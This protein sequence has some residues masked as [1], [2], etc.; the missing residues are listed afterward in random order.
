MERPD[1][2][3][4]KDSDEKPK[5]VPQA[6]AAENKDAGSS[7]PE[8][9]ETAGDGKGRKGKDRDG[10]ARRVGERL[11]N[12]A[13]QEVEAAKNEIRTDIE[14]AKAEVQQVKETLGIGGKKKGG[15]EGGGDA[16]SV[17]VGEGADAVRPDASGVGGQ[18][19][20]VPAPDGVPADAGG[21]AD[22][23]ADGGRPAS[24]GAGTAEV[25]D[26]AD[27]NTGQEQERTPEGAPV[28]NA[29]Q[30]QPVAGQVPDGA[31]TGTAP[32]QG[33]APAT[34][35]AP[36]PPVTASA[37]VPAN[38]AAGANR[39]Y[40]AVSGGMDA[41]VAGADST[42]S[43]S[44]EN[45]VT[46]S[47]ETK[48]LTGTAQAQ[49]ADINAR[50]AAA[51]AQAERAQADYGIEPREDMEN[52]IYEQRLAEIRKDKPDM[53][54]KAAERK[55]RRMARREAKREFEVRKD[56][57]YRRLAPD[58]KSERAYQRE[59][60]IKAI[61]AGLGDFGRLAAQYFTAKNAG[62]IM[63][64][65]SLSKGAI[66]DRRISDR[67]RRALV[68]A[69]E[70][71]RQ[72][73]LQAAQQQMQDYEKMKLDLLKSPSSYDVRKT[74]SGSKAKSGREESVKREFK[75]VKNASGETVGQQ[76][77]ALSKLGNN[78]YAFPAPYRNGFPTGEY[79]VPTSAAVPAVERLFEA[80]TSMDSVKN[81]ANEMAD[82]KNAWEQLHAISVSLTGGVDE[83]T[84]QGYQNQINGILDKMLKK[85]EGS[86]EEVAKD[87]LAKY[88][89]FLRSLNGPYVIYGGN[90]QGGSQASGPASVD[91]V[92]GSGQGA[93]GAGVD[94]DDF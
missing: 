69:Y 75:P 85:M 38:P 29:G 10:G 73:K 81:D 63:P 84:K 43:T 86:E 71:M 56:D 48:T 27:G 20:S 40:D 11:R 8:P 66:N 91:D 16:A 17:S 58:Y 49:L 89:E 23:V 21:A 62:T 82:I 87:A 44:V 64:F 70:Q 6:D 55:A 79:A 5:E 33:A 3:M 4:P 15:A 90:P 88:D 36:V 37:P 13:K 31:V 78:Q 68:S 92:F 53:D 9:A 24:D 76:L 93:S 1:G 80:Y 34:V 42:S 83:K 45:S 18:D 74:A 52:R 94:E 46:D 72:G 14:N 28:Q 51:A 67:E 57:I 19:S 12:A 32:T 26:G 65:S 54:E 41:N 25:A 22:G 7:A 35:P 61:I 2:G 47:V 50:Q 39:N 60:N 59:Q 77:A 30:V